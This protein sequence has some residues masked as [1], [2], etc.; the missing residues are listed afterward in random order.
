MKRNTDHMVCKYSFF[1]VYWLMASIIFF[2]GFNNY[3]GR[4][5]VLRARS[6]ST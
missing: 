5:Y 2:D 6:I 3:Y 4:I 1:I